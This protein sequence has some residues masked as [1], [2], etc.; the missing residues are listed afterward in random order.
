MKFKR[1]F[2]TAPGLKEGNFVISIDPGRGS[3][4]TVIHA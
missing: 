2:E 3:G 4:I 1:Q